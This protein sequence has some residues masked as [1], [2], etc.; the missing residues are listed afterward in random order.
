M[1]LS[2]LFGGGSSPTVV[3]NT[4]ATTPTVD[5]DAVRQR[6][7]QEAERLAATSGTSGAVKTDLQ[8][9]SLVAPKRVLLGV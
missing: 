2:G 6:E 9:K 4:T 3:A 1:C 8:P 7:M 5:S